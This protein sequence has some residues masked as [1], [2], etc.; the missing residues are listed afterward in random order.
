MLDNDYP[1]Q[2]CSIARA[3][4]VV[5]ERWSL[6]ILRDVLL[7]RHRFEELIDSLGITRTVLARRLDH[8]VEHGVLERHLYQQHPPR[9]SYQAT[10]KGRDLLQA[11]AAL[12]HW[13]DEYYPHPAGPPRM[14]LHDGCGGIVQ[15][16]LTCTMC[17]AD[18]GGP[19]VETVPGRALAG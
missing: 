15:Q 8:L 5:G 6:L 4:E 3:L 16:R 9:S 14:L 19:D 11:I 7:G 18:V 1:N 13:G 17:G 10:A 2:V 12:M